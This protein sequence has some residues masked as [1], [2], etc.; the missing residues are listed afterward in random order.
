MPLRLEVIVACEIPF[1]A[2]SV[3]KSSSQLWKL[4]APHGTAACA[5]VADIAKPIARV[6]PKNRRCRNRIA[7]RIEERARD[8]S[9]ATAAK[10]R[11]NSVLR[12][13]YSRLPVTHDRQSARYYRSGATLA[14]PRKQVS[15]KVCGRALFA[16]RTRRGGPPI[17]IR[18]D[19]LA[20]EMPGRVTEQR[21]D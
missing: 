15:R 4:L 21:N 10:T 14:A 6:Q 11:L 17:R 16:R 13:N 1:E 3:L 5:A 12:R 18:R 9:G 20:I 8:M 7:F 19:H 2:A